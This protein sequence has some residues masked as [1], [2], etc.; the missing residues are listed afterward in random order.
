MAFKTTAL[1]FVRIP[2]F[3]LSFDFPSS[4]LGYLPEIPRMWKP[5]VSCLACSYPNDSDHN[6]CQKC[7]LKRKDPEVS[8]NPVIVDTEPDRVKT[9]LASLASYRSGKPYEKQKSAL[10]KQL[11]SYLWSL[12]ERKTLKSAI[13]N[14]VVSFLVWRDKIGKS[15]VVT[16]V[17]LQGG[18]L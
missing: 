13:P 9:R 5:A 14:D 4:Q 2:I 1:E 8:E 3:I 10:Q 11:E 6:F 16:M 15:V 17:A 12:P 7:G 18:L